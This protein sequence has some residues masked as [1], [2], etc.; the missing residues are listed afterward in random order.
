MLQTECLCPSH[1]LKPNLRCNGIWRWGV[2]EE[3]R[4]RGWSPTEW[5]S[6]HRKETLGSSLRLL[7]VG[8]PCENPVR[9]EASVHQEA[10][11]TRH[12][13]CWYLGLGLPASR[14]V[15]HKF[16]LFMSLPVYSIPIQQFKWTET[17][18]LMMINFMCQ[19]DSLIFLNELF[20]NIFNKR[21][22][23]GLC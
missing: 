11:F 22:C 17:G 10:G 8:E 23:P 13:I 7:T 1:L 6:A 12:W 4:W 9:R 16:L 3:I 21:C 18:I 14:T 15:R 2:R 20:L 5:I 19:R